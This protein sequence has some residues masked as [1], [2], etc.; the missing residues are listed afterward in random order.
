MPVEREERLLAEIETN[1][2]E[3]NLLSMANNFLGIITLGSNSFNLLV[4]EN[5]AGK[6]QIIAKYKRKIRLAEGISAD[7]CLQEYAIKHGLDCLTMFAEKLVLHQIDN[8]HTLAVATATLRQVNNAQNFVHRAEKILNCPL[9]II[10]GLQE[11]ELIYQGAVQGFPEIEQRLVVDIGGASTE[12]IIGNHQGILFKSSLELGCVTTNK[13]FFDQCP[14]HLQQFA[15]VKENVSSLLANHKQQM[16]HLGWQSAIGASGSVRAV[17]EL[18]AAR[19]LPQTITLSVLLMLRDEIIA[20][21]DKQLSSIVGLDAER[22]P[23]FV[24]GIAIL[25]A[26]F[27]LLPLKELSLSQGALREGLLHQLIAKTS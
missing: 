3:A 10:S 21:K 19:N 13:H 14:Y 1:N 5:K 20:Q 12:F 7:G 22:V 26:L 16:S 27:E 8:K 2:D 24:A 11:A 17:I 4:A 9:D 18:L 25:L 6:P 23:T 15:N